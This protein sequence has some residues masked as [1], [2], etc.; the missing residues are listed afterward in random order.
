MITI[1][2][3]DI[4]VAMLV[5]SNESLTDLYV[6][7]LKEH[8]ITGDE[9]DMVLRQLE[10]MQFIDIKHRFSR[11]SG[12]TVAINS[13]LH[14]FSSRGAFKAQE[15]ILSTQLERLDIEI[16]LMKSQLTPD[17][18]DQFSKVFSIFSSVCSMLP[19]IKVAHGE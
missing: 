2:K 1:E 13:G 5:A 18:L 3:K 4:I 17:K 10:K 15:L 19:Y 12:F 7:D 8:N 11:P 6:S 14:E 16:Q 9:C